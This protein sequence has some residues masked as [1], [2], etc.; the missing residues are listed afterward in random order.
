MPKEITEIGLEFCCFIEKDN[1]S[2]P[3]VNLGCCKNFLN[4]FF[5]NV[6]SAHF[7]PVWVVRSQIRE[8]KLPKSRRIQI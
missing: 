1:P 5:Y 3:S 2:A 7:D 6:K 4:I 8:G